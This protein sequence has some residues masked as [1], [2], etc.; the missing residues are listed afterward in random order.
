MIVNQNNVFFKLDQKKF[1]AKVVYSPK[2][3][4]VTQMTKN[5]GNL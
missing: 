5:K 2:A 1:T 4:G 3:F